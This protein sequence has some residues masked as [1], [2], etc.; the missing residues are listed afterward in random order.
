MNVYAAQLTTTFPVCSDDVIME[1]LSLH[2]RG[3]R[4][5]MI[6]GGSAI[7]LLK[8]PHLSRGENR[9]LVVSEIVYTIHCDF[10]VLCRSV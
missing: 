10:I 1:L 5:K 6:K 2:K 8:R 4:G 9:G 3:K 7:P